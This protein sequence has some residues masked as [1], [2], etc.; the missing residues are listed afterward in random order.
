MEEVRISDEA[1]Q[2]VDKKKTEFTQVVIVEEGVYFGANYF[3]TMSQA[4][5]KDGTIDF[6]SQRKKNIHRMT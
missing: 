5:L 6:E 1:K 3:M 4:Q 2:M